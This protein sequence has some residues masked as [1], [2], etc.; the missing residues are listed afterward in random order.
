SYFHQSFVFT[1]DRRFGHSVIE[2]GFEST[3]SVKRI[4]LKD[5][6]GKYTFFINFSQ[7]LDLEDS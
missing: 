5:N 6:G 2:Q 7:V 1:F 3:L 4:L